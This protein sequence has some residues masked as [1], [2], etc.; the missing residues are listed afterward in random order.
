MDEGRN[1]D[2][3]GKENDLLRMRINDILISGRIA[4]LKKSIKFLAHATN[5]EF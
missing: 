4:R 2:Q 1:I 3:L 5:V